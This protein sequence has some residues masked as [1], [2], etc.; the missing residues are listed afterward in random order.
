[1]KAKSG[2]MEKLPT[3][4]RI[5]PGKREITITIEQL[6]THTSGILENLDPEREAIQERLYH[7]LRDM[8]KFAEESDLY[9]EPGTGFHY[10][11]LAYNLLAYIAENVTN[12]PFDQ[13]LEERI[14]GPLEMKSTKQYNA[15]FVE[16]KP[17]KRVRI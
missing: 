5:T 1:M 13:L 15:A 17:R 12:N 11:N 4:C 7:S 14:F 16:T 10:S 6:L 9:F 3:M 2:W 8:V